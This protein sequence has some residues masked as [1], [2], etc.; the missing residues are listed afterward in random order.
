MRERPNA[1]ALLHS[2]KGHWGL[3][4][5]AIVLMTCFNTFSHGTQDLYPTFLQK[6]HGFATH[7]TGAITITYNIGAIVGGLLF[8]TLSSRLG[9]R[10]MIALASALSLLAIPAW[11]YSSTALGLAIGAFFM[12]V[13]VQ[14]AW[15]VV[16][17]HLNELAPSG[18]RA[19]F[20]GVVYQLGNLLSSKNAVFQTY[21]AEH[22]GSVA[23]PDYSFALASFGG[24]SAVL[25]VILAL[26]GPEKRDVHFGA[27]SNP[28]EGS[29]S[30]T[31]A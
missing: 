19:T 8:G 31:T 21:I 30:S 10:K 28:P 12:Q 3:A 20:P 18:I 1:N 24:V 26:V 17:A 5:F 22:H 27:A 16:P 11:A 25:L 13:M 29:P 14:G 2:L 7:T 6:Q 9:R 23:H 4:L 15:G